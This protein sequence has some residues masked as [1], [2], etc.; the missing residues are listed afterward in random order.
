MQYSE[1]IKAQR[2]M[3]CEDWAKDIAQI[4]FFND[5]AMERYSC[6]LQD[7]GEWV[8]LGRCKPSYVRVYYRAAGLSEL[9]VRPFEKR[10]KRGRYASYWRKF[11]EFSGVEGPYKLPGCSVAID[12]VFPETAAAISNIAWVRV[13]ALD[14]SSNSLTAHFEKKLA[15]MGEN[16]RSRTA[17]YLTIAK[18]VGLSA[19]LSTFASGCE[20]AKALFTQLD[21]MGIALD[22]DRSLALKLCAINFDQLRDG[23]GGVTRVILHTA[24]FT[25]LED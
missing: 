3:I 13:V 4:A 15:Q 18:M 11:C 7:P 22:T 16:P 8:S 1:F 24:G 14:Y 17:T 2:R 10:K 21:E 25:V 9:W 6:G 12:H 5:E 19:R 20:F 23:R